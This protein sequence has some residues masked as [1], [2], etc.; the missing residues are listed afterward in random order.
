MQKNKVGAHSTRDHKEP[1]SAPK[2]PAVETPKASAEPDGNTPVDRQ[3][4]QAERDS[5][6]P[7]DQP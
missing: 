1:V 6:R 2:K 7:I 4:T 3:E 5:R